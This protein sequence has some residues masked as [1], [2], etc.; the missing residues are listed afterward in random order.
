M[1]H[2][3]KLFCDTVCKKGLTRAG[4]T[5][6]Q[7]I[8]ICGIEIPHKTP[9]FFY[10]GLHVFELVIIIIVV[11]KNREVFILQSIRNVGLPVKLCYLRLSEAVAF[12]V[13]DIAG[14]IG[15][16]SCRERV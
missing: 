13:V 11:S 3:Q 9:A 5:E 15:R 6:K 8:V 16:A 14:E 10:D 7:Q 4:R 1:S 12:F 2:I